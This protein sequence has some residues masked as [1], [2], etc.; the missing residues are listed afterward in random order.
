MNFARFTPLL[1]S[2]FVLVGCA[3]NPKPPL[4]KPSKVDLNRKGQVVKKGA[5]VFPV[6]SDTVKLKNG[7]PLAPVASVAPLMISPG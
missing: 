2:V 6:G 5:Q 4:G 1:I 3:V 7:W